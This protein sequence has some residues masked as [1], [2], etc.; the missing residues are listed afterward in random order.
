MEDLGKAPDTEKI[1]ELTKQFESEGKVDPTSN[2]LNSPTFVWIGKYDTVV[3][4]QVGLSTEEYY[5]NFVNSSHLRMDH[6]FPAQHCLPTLDFGEECAKLRPPFIG[7]CGYDGA[8]DAL[9][10]L[11]GQLNSPISAIDGNLF[12]FD[13]TP[14][15]PDPEKS[16]L[17]D[18]GYIYVPSACQDATRV[19][20]LHFS[21]HGC[22][23]TEQ[24]MGKT[25][26][27]HGG[28][29]GW[30]ES[31]NIVVVYPNAGMTLP[32]NPGG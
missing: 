15:N 9:Q 24:I 31:N 19:C 30:A 13:Q 28:Y 8:G 6:T 20:K 18:R 16:S 22:T 29:N 32:G 17:S 7:N 21:F 23:Q 5:S 2:L 26:A 10:H 3:G 11:Y 27:A 1:I 25:W 4:R 12:E 14:Y